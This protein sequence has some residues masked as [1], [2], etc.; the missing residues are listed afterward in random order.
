MLSRKTCGSLDPAPLRVAYP[1]GMTH[2]PRRSGPLCGIGFVTMV[3][4]LGCAPASSPALS[5][6]ASHSV[7]AEGASRPT[8]GGAPK[9]LALSY[10]PGPGPTDRLIARAQAGLIAHPGT[11]RSHTDLALVLMRRGRET[12]DALYS[13]YARDVL[14]AARG[15]D[16]QDYTLRVL[17]ASL[18]MEDHEFTGVGELAIALAAERPSDPT[19]KLLRGDA[20]LELGAYEDAFDAYQAAIDARPDLRSYNRAAYM[21]WLQGDFAGA[22]RITELALQSGNAH[23]PESMAWCF[24][25]LAAM[26]LHRG[27]IKPTLAVIDRALELVPTY[28]PAQALRGRALAKAGDHEGARRSLLAAIAERPA[29]DDLFALVEVLEHVGDL[30]SARST[31]ERAEALA[32]RDPRTWALFLAR[33]GEDPEHALALAQQELEARQGIWSHDVHAL[34]LLRAGRAADAKRA[35]T[36]ALVLGTPV[37]TFHLHAALIEATLGNREA[38]RAALDRSLALDATVDPPLVAELRQRLASV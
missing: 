23:D 9:L 29:A 19:P 5:E 31:R 36:K 21:R 1:R 17:W 14:V 2:R 32:A 34:S 4:A 3:S 13:T 20:A 10:E 26:Y 27:E 37:A 8:G 7:G 24:V 25:D 28:V 16:A 30:D 35:I 18:L 12:S 22:L 15:I 38:A 33:R 11:V 6:Q